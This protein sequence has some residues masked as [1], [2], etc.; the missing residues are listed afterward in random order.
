MCTWFLNLL[1]VR[2]L[3]NNLHPEVN[4]LYEIRIILPVHQMKF[5]IRICFLKNFFEIDNISPFSCIISSITTDINE[6]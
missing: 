1:I 6:I 3:Q 5:S 4:S 2:V